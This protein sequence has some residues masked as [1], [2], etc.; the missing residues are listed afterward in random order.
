MSRGAL[1]GLA[2]AA[3]GGCVSAR[4]PVLSDPFSRDP[5]APLAVYSID[6]WHTMIETSTTM[7]FVPR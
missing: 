3:L 4:A 2:L 1:L 5:G 6:Y 7:E